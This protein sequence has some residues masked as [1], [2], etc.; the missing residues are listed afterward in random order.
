MLHRIVKCYRD[1]VT[2]GK[3]FTKE[4]THLTKVYEKINKPDGFIPMMLFAGSNNQK[5]YSLALAY[6]KLWKAENLDY[7]KFISVPTPKMDYS[8]RIGENHAEVDFSL[9]SYNQRTIWL[10]IY[11]HLQMVASNT[12]NTFFIICKNMNSCETDVLDEFISYICS[13]YYSNVR[14]ILLC[15]NMNCLPHEILDLCYIMNTDYKMEFNQKI[16]LEKLLADKLWN[17]MNDNANILT[18]RELIYDVLVDGHDMYKVI[19]D[20]IFKAYEKYH[21][22]SKEITKISI[23]FHKNYSKSYR[24]IYHLETFIWSIIMLKNEL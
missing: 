24:Q 6:T 7:S 17:E 13:A 4:Y 5:N 10:P 12:D 14:L 18:I 15:N 2:Q 23:E 19:S 22:N 1:I 8:L 11:I 21:N 20:I 9:M 16:E 3:S